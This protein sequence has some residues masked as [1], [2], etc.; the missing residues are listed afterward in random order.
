MVMAE[1]RLKP[2]RGDGAKLLKLVLDASDPQTLEQALELASA[3]GSP[4]EGLLEGIQVTAA[5]ELLLSS[6]FRGTQATQDALDLLLMHQLSIAAD[7]TDEA[8]I[9]KSIRRLELSCQVLPPLNGFD[10]LEEL[11]LSIPP[12]ADWVDLSRWG[13]MPSLCN[14]V[15]RQSG[16]Q[17]HL[18]SL[19]SLKGLHAPNLVHA[20]LRG[21]GLT[22]IDALS[23]CTSL[24]SVDLSEN[25]QLASIEALKSSARSLTDLNLQSCTY[26]QSID[27]LSGSIHL[28]KLDLEACTQIQSLQALSDSIALE[29]LNLE[30]CSNLKSLA[31][32]CASSIRQNHFNHFSLKGCLALES[33]TGLP[34]LHQEVDALY[35][36]DLPCLAN[37]S[38]IRSLGAIATLELDSVGLNNF[39]DVGALAELKQLRVFNCKSLVDASELAQLKSLKQVKLRGSPGL[40]QLPTQWGSELVSL[41]LSEG[42]FTHLG[43]LPE[44]LEEL[45]VRGIPHLKNLSG[46]ETAKKLKLVCIDP[47][48]EDA[49]A[50]NGH[51]LV[52]IRCFNGPKTSVSPSWVVSAIGGVKPLRLDLR[53]TSLKELQFLVDMPDLEQLQ[54][55][56]DAC[57]FYGLKASDS[58]TE[59]AVRSVQRTICKKHKLDVPDFLKPRRASKQSA[60][61]GGPSLADVKKGLASQDFQQVVNALDALRDAADPELYDG[62][63]DGVHGPTL[64]TG[65]NASL[66]KIF[67]EIRAPYRAWARWAITHALMDSPEQSSTAQALCNSIES[68]VLGVSPVAGGRGGQA[69]RWDRFKALKSFTLQDSEDDDLRF[70]THM[71]CIDELALIRLTRIKTLSGLASMLTLP[72]LRSIK[73]EQCTSLHSLNGLESATQLQMITCSGCELLSDFQAMSGLSSLKV[74]PGWSLRSEHI[75][76]ATESGLTDVGFLSGLSSASSISLK[77]KGKVDLSAISG[78]V[79]LKK[80]QLELDSLDQDFSPLSGLQEL[81]IQLI[82]PDTGYTLSVEGKVKPG[83]SHS[84]KGSHSALESLELSGGHHDLSQLSAPALQSFKGHCRMTSFHGVGHASKIEFYLDDCVSLDGLQDSPA[85]SLDLYSSYPKGVKSPSVAVVHQMKSLKS[86][87]IGRSL[88]ERHALE[89]KSCEQVERLQANGFSGSLSFLEGWVQLREID[90]RDSGALTEIETLCSLPSLTLIRLKGSAMKREVWPK[91]LQDRLDFRSS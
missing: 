75:G 46:A 1:Q 52:S 17:D 10:A 80:L 20:N 67:R 8:E 85:A 24:S 14:L 23:V 86:L 34:P 62:V 32:L 19:S 58:L 53:F 64:Y 61:A 55:G 4:A 89:L 47:F 29:V 88:S 37:L 81:D 5:G 51:P 66:G 60:T 48:L 79:H 69:L 28:K 36:E 11:V 70:L 71:P 74:F 13:P 2:L 72:Q 30:G 44:G 59:S 42:A 45:E 7:Q 6:R 90:L 31:G 87:R 77:L 18:G 78:L 73:L 43:Q 41:E 56:H 84:W 25:A 21:I 27:A 49:R 9:R 50:L 54:V 63:L 40:T 76:I 33:L 22:S 39:N 12:N 38:G 65:D 3:I 57:D 91:P 68:I 15:I 26:L 16:D 35:L 82:D 83:Q